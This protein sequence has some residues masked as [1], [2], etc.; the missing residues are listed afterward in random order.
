LEL[1]EIET[2]SI[3]LVATVF[4]SADHGVLHMMI[5]LLLLLPLIHWNMMGS[6]FHKIHIERV[7]EIEVGLLLML[8]DDVQLQIGLICAESAAAHGYCIL[9]QL[10]AA[11][12]KQLYCCCKFIHLQS[13]GSARRRRAGT[14]CC[15]CCRCIQRRRCS[16]AAWD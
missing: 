14:C 1:V 16:P 6:S 10:I 5:L 3:D 15:R 12:G 4:M 8:L 2:C 7:R 9:L 13:R 11:A